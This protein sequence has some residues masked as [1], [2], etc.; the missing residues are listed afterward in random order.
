MTEPLLYVRLALLPTFGLTEWKMWL[1]TAIV[2]YVFACTA[3]RNSQKRWMEEQYNFRDRA[4]LAGMIL[5]D[6]HTIQ[7]WLAEQQFLTTFSAALFVA[8]FI[9]PLVLRPST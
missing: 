1:L 9:M 6:A 8:L 5:K 3:L 2:T 7:T 4:S